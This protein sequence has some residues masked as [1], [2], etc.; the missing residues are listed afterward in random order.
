MS[1]VINY[2]EILVANA[3]GI[4]LGAAMLIGNNRLF[5]TNSIGHKYIREMLWIA[6][7]G[8][9]LDPVVFMCDGRPGL[10]AHMVVYI[11]NLLMF[12]ANL[13]I[14]PL[15]VNF[16]AGY[17]RGGL[18]FKH[19][20]ALATAC[21]IGVIMLL[22]NIV[23]PFVFMVD[24]DN[25]YSRMWGYLVFVLLEI[26]FIIDGI[27][28]YSQSKRKIGMLRFFPVWVF[29]VPIAVGIAVQTMW[30]GISSIWPCVVIAVTVIVNGMNTEMSYRD[31]LTGLYNKYYLDLI[32]EKADRTRNTKAALIT[33]VMADMNSLKSINDTYG[34][35]EGDFA[36]RKLARIIN[37][38]VADNGSVVRIVGD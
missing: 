37:R 5:H 14:G 19:R 9:V 11:G 25:V 17:M 18:S 24:A 20:R 36:L 26:G 4:M 2:G 10:A 33:A 31:K 6:M 21:G 13:L 28:A 22:V 8:C 29:L 32:K 38:T 23:K 35:S 7:L 30:Y 27:I 1:H 34:H 15:W 16:T 3:M 12:I